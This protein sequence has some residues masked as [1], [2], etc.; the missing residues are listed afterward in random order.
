MY[1]L[2]SSHRKLNSPPPKGWD[3]RSTRPSGLEERVHSLAP[4]SAVNDLLCGADDRGASVL[5][6]DGTQPHLGEFVQAVGSNEVRIGCVLLDFQPCSHLLVLAL[7]GVFERVVVG[8]FLE[9]LFEL[10]EEGGD[11]LH[12]SAF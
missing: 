11:S 12:G 8:I 10:V 9:D 2:S 3:L 5:T 7:E 1:S 4:I 6:L